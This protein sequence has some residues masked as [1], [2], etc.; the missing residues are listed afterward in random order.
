MG[1]GDGAATTFRALLVNVDHITGALLNAALEKQGFDL[2]YVSSSTAYE[3]LDKNVSQLGALVVDVDTGG[4]TGFEIA[5][6]ARLRNPAVSVIFLSG[7]HRNSV[8]KFGVSGAAHVTKP[9]DADLLVM[10]LRAL[11]ASVG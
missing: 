8:E 11:A 7:A 3:S 9:F 4:I 2:T 5:H 6:Y 1:Q 10:I